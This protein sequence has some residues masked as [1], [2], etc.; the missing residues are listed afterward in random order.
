[1]QEIN[2]KHIES[3]KKFI[4]HQ[5]TIIFFLGIIVAITILFLLKQAQAVFVPFTIAWVLSRLLT[6]IMLFLK[7]KKVPT[8]LS[9][10]FLLLGMTVLFS[11]IGLIVS[12]ST[13][14]LT[15]ELP[16]YLSK[17]TVTIQKISN[18]VVKKFPQLASM[19]E[20]AEPSDTTMSEQIQKLQQNTMVEP[21]VLDIPV[22]EQKKESQQNNQGKSK[23][24]EEINKQILNL[25][26]EALNLATTILSTL[27]SIVSS[28]IMILIMLAFML[29]SAAN[30]KAKIDNAFSP[31]LSSRINS[32]IN[33]ISSQISKYLY[34]QTMISLITG[35]LVGVACKLFGISSPLTW[36]FLAFLLNYIPTVGSII[37]SVPPIIIALITYYP[38]WWPIIG[39]TVVILGIQQVMGN[40]IAP[41]LMGDSLDISPVMILFGLLLFYWMWG[42]VGAWLSVMIVATIRIV[43]DNIAPLKPIGVLLSH[44]KAYMKKDKIDNEESLATNE[45]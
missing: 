3:M 36:G 21:D 34:I 45:E 29:I 5:K 35:I 42:I 11:V 41:K 10:A 17:S 25:S 30:S 33:S 7:T 16:T 19:G 8:G 2:E 32:V 1:M 38:N 28:A 44:G 12:L 37:A 23:I 6:P 20:K 22:N 31:E 4:G 40:V 13:A 43:C 24:Q 9:V 26:K 14:S 15:H 39:I 18:E 27:T